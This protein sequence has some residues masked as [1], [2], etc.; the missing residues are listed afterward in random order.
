HVLECRPLLG[1]GPG[2]APD[3][4]LLGRPVDQ[5]GAV[6]CVRAGRAPHVRFADPRV[7]NA[8]ELVGQ[9]FL[10]R[11]GQPGHYSAAF[12]G[13][14]LLRGVTG[15]LAD[16][17][18]QHVSYR[19]DRRARLRP[20]PHQRVDNGD[21]EQPH[22]HLERA[23]APGDHVSPPV[24]PLAVSAAI[25][26]RPPM[27]ALN[28]D[29]PP[30]LFAGGFSPRMPDPS[31]AIKNSTPASQNSRIAV[32]SIVPLLWLACPAACPA[33]PAAAPPPPAPAPAAMGAASSA[34]IIVM[35]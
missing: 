14:G 22:D 8:Q 21:D 1:G 15:G 23:D 19:H 30:L 17:G 18:D 20:G 7:N 11:R 25:D 24:A 10:T 26:V 29:T 6:E 31:N 3:A 32:A 2:H 9:G 34:A 5:P 27:A 16:H 12:L 35:A 4:G 13:G 33:M 28:H